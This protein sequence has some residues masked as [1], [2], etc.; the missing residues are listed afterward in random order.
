MMASYWSVTCDNVVSMWSY[1]ALIIRLA[2]QYMLVWF[3]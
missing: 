3:Q 1:M 2:L